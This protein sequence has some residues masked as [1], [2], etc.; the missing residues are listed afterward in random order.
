MRRARREI[1]DKRGTRGTERRREKLSCSSDGR[2]ARYEVSPNASVGRG[3]RRRAVDTGRTFIYKAN[4]CGSAIPF[5]F[6]LPRYSNRAYRR[7]W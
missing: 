3:V 5:S 1:A 4:V 6:S 7:P 2:T